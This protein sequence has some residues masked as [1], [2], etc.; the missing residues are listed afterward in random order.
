MLFQLWAGSTKAPIEEIQSIGRVIFHFGGKGLR[1][2]HSSGAVD[3]EVTDGAAIPLLIRPVTSAE[4]RREAACGRI[5][6]GRGRRP[7]VKR[8]GG[9]RKRG[10]GDEL[11][12]GSGA[13]GSQLAGFE[14]CVRDQA[15]R[16]RCDGACADQTDT[17]PGLI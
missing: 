4:R 11:T 3:L 5:R 14:G 6:R 8:S 10:A 1:H 15:P 7:V 12:V 16:L 2:G 17:P 9:C 13:A